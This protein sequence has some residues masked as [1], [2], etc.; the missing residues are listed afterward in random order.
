MLIHLVP[1]PQLI[2]H[3]EREEAQCPDHLVHGVAGE[4]PV[5]DQMGRVL[6]N[7]CGRKA[8]GRLLDVAG[9]IMEGAQVC[10]RGTL[11]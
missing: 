9:Q 1:A 6:A 7:L 11:V 8:F 2:E 10:A 3:G 5:A 4:L